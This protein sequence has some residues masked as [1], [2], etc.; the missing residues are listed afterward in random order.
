[1]KMS[2]ERRDGIKRAAVEFMI[3]RSM[4][5]A[6]DKAVAML[7][8]SP[9]DEM[10]PWSRL[11]AADIALGRGDR[12]KAEAALSDAKRGAETIDKSSIAYQSLKRGL[13]Q[14]AAALQLEGGESATARELYIK[15]IAD[16]RAVL[17]PDAWIQ[18][19]YGLE[20]IAHLARRSGDW[21]LARIATENMMAHDPAYAGS[22][23]AAALLAS[24]DGDRTS[25]RA[26]LE[27]ARQLWQ[28]ADPDF[29]EMQDIARRL[30]GLS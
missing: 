11:L 25:E 30:A 14:M 16:M 23:Y 4:W 7:A 15:A 24:H 10:K 12:A 21:D 3:D 13:D 19:L 2:P 1:M 5:D 6:A 20:R 8:Q 26:A 28:K 18:A 27:K 29:P 17:G 22:H 9:Y